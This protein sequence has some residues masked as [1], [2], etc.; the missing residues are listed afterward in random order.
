MYLP[1]HALEVFVLAV[2][3]PWV[4]GQKFLFLSSQQVHYPLP[5]NKTV[6]L[7][8]QFLSSSICDTGNSLYLIKLFPSFPK[9]L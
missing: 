1:N 5:T 3:I 8:Q 9:I 7:L 6:L 2:H 4:L